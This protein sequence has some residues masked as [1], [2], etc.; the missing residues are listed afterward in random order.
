ML[1]VLFLSLKYKFNWPLCNFSKQHHLSNTK[2]SILTFNA[3]NQNYGAY[4]GLLR[5]EW[6]VRNSCYTIS[7]YIQLGPDF[8]IR[9]ADIRR[10]K[11]MF[12]GWDRFSSLVPLVGNYPFFPAPLSLVS[13]KFRPM[14]QEE[15]NLDGTGS[16]WISSGYPPSG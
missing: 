3:S 2:I 10:M 9:I 15:K 6:V 5:R 1:N 13:S 7:L 16:I 14:R 12:F 8:V 4:G 11:R